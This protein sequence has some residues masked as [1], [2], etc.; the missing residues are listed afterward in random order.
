MTADV[1]IDEGEQEFFDK[2]IDLLLAGGYFRAR[3]ATLSPFDRVIGGMA[4]C[5]TA[6]SGDLDVDILFEENASLGEKVRL[7]E[8]VLAGLLRLGCP[9]QLETYQ[10]RSLRYRAIFPVIQWLIKK[11]IEVREE[12]GDLVRA[13]SV[14]QFGKQYTAPDDEQFAACRDDAA[15]YA[16]HV[17]SHYRARRRYQRN[18]P[19]ERVERD[20]AHLTLLEYGSRIKLAAKAGGDGGGG[21]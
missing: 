11:V 18:A 12:T 16:S 4:Y 7:G 8:Q 15:R 17:A 20:E 1:R 19:P 2:I 10:I 14:E 5:I 21:G 3:I 9:L 13:Y 6:S